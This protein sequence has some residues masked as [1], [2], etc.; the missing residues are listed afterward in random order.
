M[1]TSVFLRYFKAV[2]DESEY[3]LIKKYTKLQ[4]EKK[5]Q[6]MSLQLKT[7]FHNEKQ[8][9]VDLMLIYIIILGES[10]AF[11]KF[12]GKVVQFG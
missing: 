4:L 7:S 9:E 1:L 3:I 5:T 6:E 10:L 12:L 2:C 11:E 8:R